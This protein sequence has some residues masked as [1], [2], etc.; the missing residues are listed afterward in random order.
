MH[1][2]FIEVVAEQLNKNKKVSISIN[3]N[4]DKYEAWAN[5]NNLDEFDKST[6]EKF[7][8]TL[9]LNTEDAEHLI[10]QFEK[11]Y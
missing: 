5:E 9:N 7:V 3:D 8:K 1:K 10:N 4:A 2:R 11:Y 6:F